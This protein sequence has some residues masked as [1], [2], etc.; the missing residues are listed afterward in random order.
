MS[1]PSRIL[2]IRPSALGDVCRTVPVLASLRRTYPDARIDWLVQDSFADAILHHPALTHAVPFPRRLLGESIRRLDIAPVMGFLDTLAEAHYDLVID[3]QGLARS[4][5]FAY[6]TGAHRRVGLTNAREMGWLGLNER[7]HVPRDVH[8]VDRMLEVL[9]LAGIQPILDMRLYVSDTARQQLHSLGHTHDG[10]YIVLAPTS[11][12]PAKRWPVD[13]FA[14]VAEQLAS[15]GLPVVLVGGKSERDQCEPLI[16]LAARNPLILDLIGQTTVAQLMALIESSALVI[17]N[18]SAA[19][20]MAVGFD[21]PLIALY[22]P[23]RVDLVGPYRREADVI[24]HITPAD[25]LDHK[26]GAHVSLMHRITT[27]E[28]I[29]AADQRL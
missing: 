10:P 25:E 8:T 19:L 22:G 12:W 20:H 13:R 9:R 11:R 3:V 7:H 14:E 18:D 17:A 28:V 5:F 16:D 4:G 23:T 21:R 26:L 24:Q 27:D 6:W 2:L 15:R 29:T 1:L